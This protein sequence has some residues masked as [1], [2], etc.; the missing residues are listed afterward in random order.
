M[1]QSLEDALAVMELID[2]SRAIAWEEEPYAFAQLPGFLTWVA[3]TVAG[4]YKP[5]SS[6]FDLMGRVDADPVLFAGLLR[7][8]RNRLAYVDPATGRRRL[9]YS[10]K[11]LAC[12]IGCSSSRI[13]KLESGKWL[14]GEPPSVWLISSICQALGAESDAD[15]LL[16]AAGWRLRGIPEQTKVMD[17]LRQCLARLQSIEA[18]LEQVQKGSARQG[19][20][21]A[22]KLP[23]P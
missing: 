10:Q 18:R 14:H 20:P 8:F 1:R 4:P 17:L 5:D 19:G 23:E 2:A 15:A 9:L 22:D 3:P 11:S 16:T 12:A 21:L 7:S 6:R 13:S